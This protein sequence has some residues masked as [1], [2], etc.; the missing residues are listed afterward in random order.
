[1]MM[2][3]S[4]AYNNQGIWANQTSKPPVQPRNVNSLPSSAMPSAFM[5]PLNN[6]PT[7]QIAPTP[8]SP[9]PNPQLMGQ[10]ISQTQPRSIFE[11]PSGSYNNPNSSY[12]YAPRNISPDV[13]KELRANDNVVYEVSPTT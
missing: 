5:S 3:V 11:E 8:S 10:I 6:Q 4:N 12:K 1:M 13:K 9:Y 2:T 7:V